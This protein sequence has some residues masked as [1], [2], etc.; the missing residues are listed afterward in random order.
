MISFTNKFD[1]KCENLGF[2]VPEDALVL[3]TSKLKGETKDKINKFL[4]KV[5]K[6]QDKKKIH[7]F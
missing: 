3:K 2:F 7:F 6:N 5:K 1:D 4:K